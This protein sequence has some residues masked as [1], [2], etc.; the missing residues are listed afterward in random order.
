M[1]TATKAAAAQPAKKPVVA[2]A[3][4]KSAMDFLAG[5][6][7][8]GRTT[9]HAPLDRVYPD[10]NQPRTTFRELSGE[11]DPLAQQELEELA[12]SIDDNGLKEPISLRRH[13]EIADAWMIV[14]GERRWRA[15]CLNRDRGRPGSNTIEAF[16]E[17]ESDLTRIR[18]FQLIENIDR[19]QLTDMETAS[20]MKLLLELNP[21]W[22]QKD[23]T[24]LFNRDK[25]WVSRM[26]GLMDPRYSDLINAGFITYATILE[27]FKGLPEVSQQRLIDQAKTSGGKITSGMIREEKNRNTP[28]PAV[29]AAPATQAVNVAKNLADGGVKT[30][31]V[32]SGARESV[33]RNA[34]PVAAA[35]AQQVVRI[36]LHQ[37]A[38]LL[39][40]LPKDERVDASITL[41]VDAMRDAIRKLGHTPVKDNV[42][43]STQ[44]ID[45]LNSKMPA[46]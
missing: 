42:M 8:E 21:S 40:V 35:M 1:A 5:I 12:Q 6:Q 3:A 7:T 28:A 36:Q 43:L 44:L 18:V 46:K 4:R 9:F 2:K 22:R 45:A 30:A 25:Q 11:V 32:A 24:K 39:S 26:L 16:E 29:S 34:G 37:I 14:F 38:M 20:H 31:P 33:A 10:P 13:P 17:T 19:S 41:T 15:C 23:L 27:N